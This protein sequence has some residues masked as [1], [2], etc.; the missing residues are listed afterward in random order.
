MTLH[1]E[2]TQQPRTLARL[3]SA[4]RPAAAEVAERVRSTRPGVILIA[5]RGTSDN[6]A[7]YAQYLWG[8]RAGL[9]VGLAAPALFGPL[10]APPALDAAFVV[11]IS[12]SGASPDLVAVVTE[13]RRQG[14]PTVA[15][16]NDPSSPLAAAADHVVDLHAGP[17]HA[18]A[19]TKT[20]TA[21]LAVVAMIA[22]ELAPR[23]GDAEALSA[24]PDAVAAA[25]ATEAA[26]AACAARFA[27][28]QRAAVLGRGLDLAIAHEWALKTQE[29]TYVLA[30]PASTADF[31]HGPRAVVE[32]G[33]PV[34]AVA[35]QEALVDGTVASLAD[36]RGQGARTLV[37]TDRPGAFADVA[38]EILVIPRRVPE[39]LAP[40]PAVVVGQLWALHLSRARGLDPDLPRALSKVT[41]T[42]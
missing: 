32:P 24:V 3:L 12:Q 19:A 8:E 42:R 41:R 33:F 2:L 22:A 7:R 18:V 20:F 15:I 21:Q 26:V 30:Q 10:S 14:R 38:D 17:E 40:I 4:V 34:L 13:A 5:A 36:L 1:D 31:A 37:L 6:A 11:G 39:W 25:L 27:D 9:T 28:V 23:P 35:T 29:L 16:T